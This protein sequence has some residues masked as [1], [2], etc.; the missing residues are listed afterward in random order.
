M[1]LK[2]YINELSQAKKIKVDTQESSY[3]IKATLKI[4]ADEYFH[5]SVEKTTRVVASLEYLLGVDVMATDAYNDSIDEW[6]IYF[7]DSKQSEFVERKG[8]GVAIRLFAT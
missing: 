8:K 5:V 1:R 7:T 4:T 3:Q 6:I 2:E